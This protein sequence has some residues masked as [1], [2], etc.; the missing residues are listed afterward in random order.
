MRILKIILGVI[1]LAIAAA[2]YALTAGMW[3]LHPAAIAVIG[4]VGS[5]L[6]ALGVQAIAVPARLAQIFGA[7]AGLIA[8]VV[9]IHAAN[10]SRLANPHPWVWATVTAIGVLMGAVGRLQL[11]QKAL[12]PAPPAPGTP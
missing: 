7:A 4:A 12:P 9:G 6:L 5:F 1:A 3:N 8:T 2:Q 11:P 10:V